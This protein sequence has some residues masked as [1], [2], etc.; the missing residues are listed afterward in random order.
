MTVFTILPGWRQCT[1][2]LAAGLA[3]CL[4]TA[5]VQSQDSLPPSA[6]PTATTAATDVQASE[7]KLPILIVDM[8]P[9]TDI[10]FDLDAAR[11][12]KPKAQADEQKAGGDVIQSTLS[13]DAEEALR[14]ALD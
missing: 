9:E 11:A 8:R 7:P 6:S 2:G 10:Q 12:L 14:Q 1:G 3:V 5:T 4:V 13:T